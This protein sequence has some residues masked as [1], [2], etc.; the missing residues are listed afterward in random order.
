MKEKKTENDL[1]ILDSNE[2]V[3][4]LDTNASVEGE[5]Q[6]T[7]EPK[8]IKPWIILTSIVLII[9][10]IALGVYTWY[11]YN[12]L[13][14]Y[15]GGRV[16]R[17]E[18]NRYFENA[19][20]DA[21][22]TKDEVTD[23]DTAMDNLLLSLANE[24]VFYKQLESL[25]VG[26]LTAEELMDI[27]T[28]SRKIVDDYVTANMDTI[29]AGLPEG[30]SDRDLQKATDEFELN[31]L[32]QSGYLDFQSYLEA[33]IKTRIFEKAYAELL[34]DEEVAPTED[35]V[36]AEFDTM[37]ANQKATYDG[38]PAA[39][40]DEVDSLSFSVYVPDGIRYVRHILIKIDEETF[41]EISAF[42]NSG[43]QASADA[44]L[45][46]A[47]AEIK[48]KADEVLAMLDA[49]EI[50]FTEAIA[51]YGEDPGMEYYPEGYQV[52]EGYEGYVPEF[53]DGSMAL[54]NVGDYSGLVSTMYGYH[55]IE[56]FTKVPSEVAAYEDVH[57]SIYS[58][59]V[60]SNRSQ[61][62]LEFLTIWPQELHLDFKNSKLNDISMY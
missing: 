45:E 38:N 17:A 58:Y 46:E 4:E 20:L 14:T 30:Y 10:I 40:L 32:N 62:W 50:T 43:D 44:L 53:T 49:G 42:L 8:R 27:E 6:T 56:Y 2:T 7:E 11:S 9:A 25:N 48:P 21:G 51:E 39:F 12:T 16:T 19:L 22:L 18:L 55:I 52:C 54:E 15:D 3:V 1:S 59:L 23:I 26:V 24:E 31:A 41:N 47:L 34:P 33:N 13:A 37:V 29:I 60:D 35:A 5:N 36:K 28:S 57:D 61:K